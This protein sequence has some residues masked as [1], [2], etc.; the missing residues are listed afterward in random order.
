MKSV[1]VPVTAGAIGENIVF[2]LHAKFN[3]DRLWNEKFLVLWKS[4]NN[5][6]KK[7]PKN[8]NKN[9]MNSSA[10]GPVWNGSNNKNINA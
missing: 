2:N 5:N 1:T 10:W 6:H 4:D 8:K 7:K 3:N 9:N